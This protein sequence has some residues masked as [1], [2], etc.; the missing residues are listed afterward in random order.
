MWL[1]PTSS[2]V[3]VQG[4]GLGPWSEAGRRSRAY[5]KQS[6][7]QERSVFRQQAPSKQTRGGLL[8]MPGQQGDG[9]A[10]KLAMADQRGR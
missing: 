9:H 5:A 6:K 7:S 1:L 3:S 10:S 8:A 4:H 2:C